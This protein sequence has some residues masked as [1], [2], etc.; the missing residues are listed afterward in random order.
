MREKSGRQL[1][2][3]IKIKKRLPQKTLS[4]KSSLNLRQ[5]AVDLLI[6]SILKAPLG[7]FGG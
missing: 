4:G 6:Y 7:G 5:L 2:T 1:I 3:E